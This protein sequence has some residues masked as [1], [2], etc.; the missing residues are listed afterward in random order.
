MTDSGSGPTRHT[1]KA[2]DEWLDGQRAR[3]LSSP[4]DEGPPCRAPR[5]RE[6]SGL[7]TTEWAA[8]DPRTGDVLNTPQFHLAQLGCLTEAVEVQRE[9]VGIGDVAVDPQ[10]LHRYRALR[11]DAD[12]EYERETGRPA[13]RT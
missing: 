8:G 11:Q 7:F 1:D 13:Q 9:A 2:V 3:F 10:A 4:A 12:A 5:E 6:A